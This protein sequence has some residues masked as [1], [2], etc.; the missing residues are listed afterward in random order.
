MSQ[1]LVAALYKFVSL[2]DCRELQAPLQNACDQHG[3]KGTLLLAKEGINGTLAA[4]QVFMLSSLTC[5]ASHA[6]P[7]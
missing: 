6:L 5:A 2:P 7:T 4:M 1:F 3:V